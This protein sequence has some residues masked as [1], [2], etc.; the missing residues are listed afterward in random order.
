MEGGWGEVLLGA[1]CCGARPGRLTRGGSCAGET[2]G[3][4]ALAGFWCVVLPDRARRAVTGTGEGQ[5]GAVKDGDSRL[6]EMCDGQ[7]TSSECKQRRRCDAMRDAGRAESA[8]NRQ[9]WAGD[10]RGLHNARFRHPPSPAE[11]IQIDPLHPSCWDKNRHIR[12]RLA[13]RAVSL[14]PTL[15]LCDLCI[16]SRDRCL[17]KRREASSKRKASRGSTLGLGQA[18]SIAAPPRGTLRAACQ[19]LPWACGPESGV[20]GVRKCACFA[21]PEGRGG[22]QCQRSSLFHADLPLASATMPARLPAMATAST[23]TLSRESWSRA[24][25]RDV[26]ADDLGTR[27]SSWSA[28]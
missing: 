13:A 26:H 24:P 27:R 14:W 10:E 21:W 19:K 3:Q 11:A 20:G 6:C 5:A 4:C 15:S 18:V 23:C 22:M 25:T 7:R 17:H 2:G 28:R 16:P 9:R 1:R 12:A 8:V